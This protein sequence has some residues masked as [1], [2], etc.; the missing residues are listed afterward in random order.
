MDLLHKQ[1]V[2]KNMNELRCD[3]AVKVARLHQAI[4]GNPFTVRFTV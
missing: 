1:L 2:Y 3:P 4:F